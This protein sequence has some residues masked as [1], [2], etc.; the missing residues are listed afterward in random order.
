MGREELLELIRSLARS[1]W[2][3]GRLLQSIMELDEEAQNDFWEY[4]ES[5]NFKDG[6]EFILAYEGGEL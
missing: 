5:K 1:Q 4:L 3:Y 6:V 2:L